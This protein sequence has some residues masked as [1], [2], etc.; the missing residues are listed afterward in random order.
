[1][2]L[3]DKSPEDC[4]ELVCNYFKNIEAKF[5]KKPTKEDVASVIGMML[6]EKM[7]EFT[8]A[9]FADLTPT[10]LIQIGKMLMQPE[11]S[12]A[13]EAPAPAPADPKYGGLDMEKAEKELRDMHKEVVKEETEKAAKAA[14]P[15]KPRA[16]KKPAVCSKVD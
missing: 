16:P 3:W 11:P 9:T 7:V 13:P 5:G 10:T 2:S 8:R 6:D 4:Q 14:K 1:M 15:K 12:E